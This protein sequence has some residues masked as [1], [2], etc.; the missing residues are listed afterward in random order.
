MKSLSIVFWTI[1]WAVSLYS[2]FIVITLL[3]NE[4]R[5]LYWLMDATYSVWFSAVVGVIL[6][7]S[8][9]HLI[10]TINKLLRKE[11]TFAG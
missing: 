8:V 4:T 3:F 1:V 11:N 2:L 10:A 9:I 6:M 5:Y 7:F